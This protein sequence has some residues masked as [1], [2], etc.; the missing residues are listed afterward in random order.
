MLPYSGRMSPRAWTIT[1]SAVLLGGLLAA[2]ALLPVPFVTMSPGPTE[3]TLGKIKGKQIIQIDG[4]RTYRTNGQLDLTTV[5]VTSPDQQ[6]DLAEAVADWLNPEAAVVPRSFVYPDSETPRQVE[7]RNAVA[8]QTSQQDAVAAALT[9]VGKEFSADSVVVL[10]IIK[11]APALG[12]LQLG[13]VIQRVDGTPIETPRDVADAVL[14]HK[15]REW[16]SFTVERDGE[17]VDVRIKTTRKPN[18][19]DSAMVGITP[20]VGY[21]FHPY[22]IKV[23]LDEEIGG[24]SAGSMFALAMV[25]RMQPGSLTDGRHIAGTGTIDGEGR[26]GPIGG[27]QQKLAGAKHSGATIFLVPDANCAEAAAADVADLRLIRVK[28]LSD[29]VDA[30]KA[31]KADPDANV[32]TCGHGQ[33]ASAG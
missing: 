3:D 20:A 25:D 10:K 14:K 15:P 12:K 32:P 1:L 5:A 17:Q 18:E 27:I 28:T 26:V 24:P 21:D 4:T 13:D 23:N 9:E 11:G 22:D 33:Q 2:A 7:Q 6:L 16:V 30:L 31:T 19:P 29:A 8:M